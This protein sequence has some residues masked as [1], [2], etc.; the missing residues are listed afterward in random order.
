MHTGEYCEILN[1]CFEVNRDLSYGRIELGYNFGDH[2]GKYV[3]AVTHDN[4]NVYA[5]PNS[6]DKIMEYDAN[7]GAVNLFGHVPN[8]DFSYTGGALAAG[9]HIYG[10]PRNS[11]KLLK[12]DPQK[13]TAEEIDLGLDYETCGGVRNHHYS[14]VIYEGALI[15]APRFS[16]CILKID[17]EDYS[18][19]KLFINDETAHY[20]GAILH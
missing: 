3:G 10:F 1:T 5:I 16:D 18:V 12:I 14:G 7:T 4:G 20:N 9:G 13:R 8:L 2:S 11:N 6:F 17:L 15:C 19:H